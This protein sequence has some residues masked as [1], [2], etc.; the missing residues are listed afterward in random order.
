MVQGKSAELQYNAGLVVDGTLFQKVAC[1]DQLLRFMLIGNPCGTIYGA[2]YKIID[3]LD[4]G[5][6]CDRSDSIFEGMR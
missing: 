5:T 2:R 3:V 1:V 4:S 6:S